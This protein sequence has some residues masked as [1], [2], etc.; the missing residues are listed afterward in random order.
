MKPISKAVIWSTGS[1]L[2]CMLGASAVL[3]YG[4]DEYERAWG[5]GP[6]LQV[7][8]YI[9]LVLA[10][11]VMVLSAV[12]FRW[13]RV[14]LDGVRCKGIVVGIGSAAGFLLLSYLTPNGA[15]INSYVPFI[16]GLFTL[17]LSFLVARVSKAKVAHAV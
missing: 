14:D 11:G 1:F 8:M 6:S 17:A 13:A 7:L 15:E 12:G 2:L 9:A 5:R 10:A 3:V 16:S 4:F